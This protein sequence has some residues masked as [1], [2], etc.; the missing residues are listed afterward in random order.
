MPTVTFKTK[1]GNPI[2]GRN[3]RPGMAPGGMMVPRGAATD[4]PQTN[5]ER[6]RK[7]RKKCMEVH[8]AAM[9]FLENRVVRP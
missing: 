5:T 4:T 9:A 8:D 1:P 7:M 6:A 2:I 3:I